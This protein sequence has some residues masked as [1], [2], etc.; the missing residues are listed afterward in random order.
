MIKCDQNPQ[1][2]FH[3][4]AKPIGP[5]CNLDYSYCFYLHGRLHRKRHFTLVRGLFLFCSKKIMALV[6]GSGGPGNCHPI[7]RDLPLC[8][9]LTGLAL[10]PGLDAPDF[11]LKRCLEQA[12]NLAN[13]LAGIS[14]GQPDSIGPSRLHAVFTNAFWRCFGFSK[15][16]RLV[17]PTANSQS[18]IYHLA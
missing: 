15:S 13:G 18:T 12:T 3:V 14:R 7:C 6:G 16:L 11:L 5:V 1:T 10:F 4:M 17:G 2:R 9:H 8:S